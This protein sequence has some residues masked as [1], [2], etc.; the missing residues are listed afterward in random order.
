MT[1]RGTY[2]LL[3]ELDAPTTVSFGAQG[4]RDLPSGWYAYTGTAFG[5]GGFSRVER[6]RRVARGD[7]DARHWHVDYLL[8]HPDARLVDD[9][10]TP[11]ADAECSVARRMCGDGPA[12]DG[13]N[14]AEPI[15]G[16]DE[17]SGVG[18]TDCDCSAHLH[19]PADRTTLVATVRSAHE[20]LRGDST[21]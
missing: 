17:V 19:G 7:N 16:I 1:E 5:P 8:G 3:V 9:V 10:R 12:V 6:H 21:T 4:A 14:P 20:G 15:D 11:G 18:A 2:T 13:E